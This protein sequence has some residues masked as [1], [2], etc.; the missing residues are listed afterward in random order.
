MYAYMWVHVCLCVCMC[1]CMCV[2]VCVACVCS[3]VCM[4]KCVTLERVQ[5]C[6]KS[7]KK[8]VTEICTECVVRHVLHVLSL[9]HITMYFSTRCIAYDNVL[10]MTMYCILLHVMMYCTRC[11]AYDDVLQ[12]TMLFRR[13]QHITIAMPPCTL[14]FPAVSNIFDYI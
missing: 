12:S 2:R 11:R 10:H 7:V 4:C 5:F 8:Y 14:S 3:S 13:G 1:G 6:Q 9:L